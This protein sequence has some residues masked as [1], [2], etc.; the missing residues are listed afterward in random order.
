MTEILK[1][2]V[3]GYNFVFDELTGE[4]STL[5]LKVFCFFLNFFGG[6]I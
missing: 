6:L 2:A 4:L 1:K 5:E 3:Y